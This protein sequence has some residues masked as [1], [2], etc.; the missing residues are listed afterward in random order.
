MKKF[1]LSLVL[2][3]GTV[4]TSF[5]QGDQTTTAP[6]PN[7]PIITFETNVLDYGTIKQNSEP[8]RTIKFTNTGKSPLIIT[9]CAGSCGCTVPTCPVEPIMPGEKGEIQV[10]Y[11]TDR[12]GAFNKTVTI[13]SNAGNGT[14]II[15]IKG[16]VEPNDG[17]LP[18]KKDGPTAN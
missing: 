18:V 3:A 11:A 1:I 8:F 6:D 17:G 16:T 15:T 7:A 4:F 13:N 12:M 10:R 5:A 14:V 2:A 9:N